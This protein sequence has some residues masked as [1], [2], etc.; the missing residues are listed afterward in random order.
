ME[1]TEGRDEVECVILVAN[2]AAKARSSLT[3]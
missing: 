2:T 3:N 1:L